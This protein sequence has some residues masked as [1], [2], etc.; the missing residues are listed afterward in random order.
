MSSFIRQDSIAEKPKSDCCFNVKR[1]GIPIVILITTTTLY[2]WMK[3]NHLLNTEG[4][5]NLLNCVVGYSANVLHLVEIL[6]LL[7]LWMSRPSSPRANVMAVQMNF[8]KDLDSRMPDRSGL[9]AW[10]TAFEGVVQSKTFQEALAL[11][12]SKPL[13]LKRKYKKLCLLDIGTYNVNH[14]SIVYRELQGFLNTLMS[15]NK[16]ELF[17]L[18]FHPENY[19]SRVVIACLTYE[20]PE[21]DNSPMGQLMRVQ[22]MP[23]K[24][25]R[26]IHENY[27]DY[28]E[29]DQAEEDGP[30]KWRQHR[31]AQMKEL[32]DHVA[33]TNGFNLMP[34]NERRYIVMHQYYKVGNDVM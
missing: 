5:S 15:N 33:E 6:A 14:L 24:Q 30:N 34:T 11:A 8:L 25:L 31:L 32:A 21:T 29:N 16:S 17:E 12:R 13:A 23:L 1:I 7:I 22:M 9:N 4:L 3:D 28:V 18:G 10:V 2:L 26:L 19:K 20:T 27:E